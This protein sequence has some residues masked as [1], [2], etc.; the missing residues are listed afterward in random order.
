MAAKR[1]RTTRTQRTPLST[2]DRLEHWAGVILE[3]VDSKFAGFAEGQIVMGESIRRDMRDGFAE[4]GAR[5]GRLE[6]AVVAHSGEIRNLTTRV[7]A[8]ES[9]HPT[10]SPHPRS[11][12]SRKSAIVARS[13]LVVVA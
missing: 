5:I 1:P 11:G 12:L 13:G 2:E 9:G 3:H 7:G 8:V 4:Q 6:S 10:R